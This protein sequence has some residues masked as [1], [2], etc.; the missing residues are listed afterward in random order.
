MAELLVEFDTT[1]RADDGTRWYPRVWG[2]IADDALWEGWVEFLPAG[3]DDREAIRTGR[4]TEQPKRSDLLYWAQGLTQ[5][6]LEGALQR[7]R[8]NASEHASDASHATHPRQEAQS[9][10]EVRATRSSSR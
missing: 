2:A 8:R 6:Y 1:I 9:V 5:V 3:T 7:A 10:S 4:E